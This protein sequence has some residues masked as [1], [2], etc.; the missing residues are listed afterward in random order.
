M[1]DAR[2]GRPTDRLRARRRMQRASKGAQPGE[3]G[4]VHGQREDE[5]EVRVLADEL[6]DVNAVLAENGIKTT[7]ADIEAEVLS[8]PRSRTRHRP[9]VRPLNYTTLGLDGA[10]RAGSGSGHPSVSSS[11]L[12]TQECAWVPRTGIFQRCA[13]TRFD[14][15]VQPPR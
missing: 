4:Q 12:I 7:L 8:A 11:K 10:G 2:R 15:A 14:V 13:A 5:T 6:G 9:R 3:E 1:A